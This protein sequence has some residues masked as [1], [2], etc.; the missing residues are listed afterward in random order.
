MFMVHASFKEGSSV[1]YCTLIQTN[2]IFVDSASRK[3]FVIAL[4]PMSKKKFI[5]ASCIST[6]DIDQQY[7][8][9]F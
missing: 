9:L 6:K 3:K 8:K 5:C 4:V 1:T 7:F 2:S